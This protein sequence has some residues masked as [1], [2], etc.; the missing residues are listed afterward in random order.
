MLGHEPGE[1]GAVTMV[2]VL[3][4]APRLDKLAAKEFGEK[5]THA[6]VDLREQV[7]FRR[8]ERVVQVED[9]GLHVMK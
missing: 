9:P 5:G 3:L 7:A 6:L 4:H 1:R 8:I 2:I